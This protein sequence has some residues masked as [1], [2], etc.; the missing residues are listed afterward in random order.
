[1]RIWSRTYAS[2][3]RFATEHGCVAHKT[4]EGAVKDADIICTVTFDKTPVL[5]AGWVKP[6][7]HINGRE[8]LRCLLFWH[9]L[10]S[11]I[12]HLIPLLYFACFLTWL[13]TWG[14]LR[15]ISMWYMSISS[16][17]YFKLG[18]TAQRAH[19]AITTSPLRQNDIAT[20]FWRNYDVIIASWVRWNRK[21]K[22]YVYRKMLVQE[23]LKK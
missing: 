10:L 2:A 6:G 5:Q 1:M 18:P 22:D 19:D 20:S 17:S 14:W 8:S 21:Y 23:Y 3:E 4:V 12:Y 7:A 15:A 13:S 9:M 16:W 11:L